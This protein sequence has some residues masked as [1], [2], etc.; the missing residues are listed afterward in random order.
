M[1]VSS[2][3]NSVPTWGKVLVGA[4]AGAAVVGGVATL[5]RH[6]RIAELLHNPRQVLVVLTNPQRPW[7][8]RTAR[9]VH[10]DAMQAQKLLYGSTAG[11]IDDAADAFRHAYAAGLLK[12]RLM[13][14]HG[15]A[16]ADAARLVTRIGR[17]HELDGVDN[18]NALSAAM[19]LLNNAAGIRITGDGH[20]SG[21]SW[22]T[23][24][25]LRARV[26]AALSS[27][28]LRQLA[29]DGRRL[30]ATRA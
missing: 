14:D 27:G 7:L 12:L 13:R 29:A 8:A 20:V 1:T 24:V 11:H 30:V 21:D 15:M 4:T 5:A 26:R 22:I 16:D 28:S 2:D 6:G 9:I 19:D 10:A 25:S 18:P 3:P 17:A 23:D